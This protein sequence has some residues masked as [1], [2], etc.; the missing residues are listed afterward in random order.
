MQVR[1]TGLGLIVLGLVFAFF[2]IYMPVRDGPAGVMGSV[3]NTALL[4]VPLSIITGVAFVI[5]GEQV[6]W[7]FQAKPKSRGQLVLVLSIIIGSWSIGGYLF[8]QIKTN[9]MRAPEPVILDGSPKFPTLP[10]SR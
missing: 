1:L 7:A 9:W 10:K 5:G 8:W 6:L 2:F 3:R 4:F